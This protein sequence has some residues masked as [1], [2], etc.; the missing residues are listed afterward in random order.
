MLILFQI[1]ELEAKLGGETNSLNKLKEDI[2]K[3]KVRE[4]SDSISDISEQVA[5]TFRKTHRGNQY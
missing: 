3:T 4:F 1:E 2:E 5:S